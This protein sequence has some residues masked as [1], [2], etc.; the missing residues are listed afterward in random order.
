VYEGGL[1]V[2]GAARWPGKIKPGTHTQQ[3]AL[4]MDIFATLCD[5]GGAKPP[6]GIDGV[7]FLPTLLGQPQPETGRDLYF[8]L[9]EG[10]PVFGG[11]TIEALIRGPWKLIQDR[12][13]AAP[14][15]YNLQRDPQETTDLAAKE[16]R[17]LNDLC[18]AMRKHI[19]RGGQ[20]PWQGTDPAAACPPPSPQT[21]ANPK[22]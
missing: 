16:R 6:A 9:R 12:P 10:G 14:E 3:V 22:P 8:V 11:K 13:G 5:A 20:V 21:R 19:Q 7:S 2:P 18:A 4:S 15:L 1:R 17:V